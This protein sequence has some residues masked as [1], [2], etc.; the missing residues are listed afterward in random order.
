MFPLYFAF[1]FQPNS[2]VVSGLIQIFSRAEQNGRTLGQATD[3]T[4]FSTFCLGLAYG[5]YTS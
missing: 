3:A 5:M 2:D 4:A 1:D